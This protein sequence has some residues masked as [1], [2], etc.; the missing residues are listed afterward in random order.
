MTRAKFTARIIVSANID[1][2]LVEADLQNAH[3]PVYVAV[4]FDDISGGY[5]LQ[6]HLPCVAGKDL[7]GKP[8]AF[9]A[10]EKLVALVGTASVAPLSYINVVA[11]AIRTDAPVTAS[12]LPAC[13]S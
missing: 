10:L 7:I 5:S 1:E 8:A 11:A 2:M 4:I 6:F 9:P 3:D 12:Q 13:L